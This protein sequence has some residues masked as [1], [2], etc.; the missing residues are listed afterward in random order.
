MCEVNIKSCVTK[1]AKYEI[2]STCDSSYDGSE[3]MDDDLN[4]PNY[5]KDEKP[6]N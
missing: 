5:T 6:K 2:K 3:K 1:R 4:D